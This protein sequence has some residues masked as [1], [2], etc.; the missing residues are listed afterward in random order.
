MV[1]VHVLSMHSRYMY[2][3]DIFTM[4][5]RCMAN[6]LTYMVDILTRYGRCMVNA[7]TIYGRCMKDAW[8]MNIL[9]QISAAPQK[10]SE[11]L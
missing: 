11:R 3:V 1:D 8:S 10:L 5:G 7:L 4:Y 2:M 9:V 6:A